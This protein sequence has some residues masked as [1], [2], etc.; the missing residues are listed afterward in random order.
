MYDGD[1]REYLPAKHKA[2][3]RLGVDPKPRDLP[4]NAEIRAA[5]LERARL[6]EDDRDERLKA[7]RLLALGLMRELAGFRP[8][9]I[10]SVWTG[11]VRKGSD[12]DLHIFSRSTGAVCAVLDSL[13]LEHTVEHKQVRYDGGERIY[14]HIHVL[15]AFPVEL[16]VYAPELASYPFRSSITGKPIEKGDLPALEQRCYDAY[17]ALATQPEAPEVDA[18]SA[19]RALLLPLEDVKQDPRWHPEGDALFHSLQVY[20]LAA[21]REP[22]DLELQQAAL[23]HD[24][25]KGID[26]R[27]HV[28][29]GVAALDGLVSERVLW[30]VEHHMD[31]QQALDGALRVKRK[32][33]L[34][35]SEHYPDLLTLARCDRQGRVPGARVPE[36]DEVL[37]NLRALQLELG[38]WD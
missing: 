2:A 19:F 21:R 38:A 24:V 18:L 33:A 23:L 7:M 16:T 36:L 28:E 3:R 22:W 15:M 20:D 17:G 32:R 26:P 12:I 9:L 14:T 27:A 37:A 11:H 5:I 29:A 31:G 6:L 35:A 1:V 13:G 30:L 10:G 25:G 4:S 34:K 8:R